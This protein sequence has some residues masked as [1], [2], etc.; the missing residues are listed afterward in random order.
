MMLHKTQPALRLAIRAVTVVF[1]LLFFEAG[2]A[3]SNNDKQQKVRGPTYHFLTKV[4][5]LMA[6]EKY[7]LA[8]NRID[9]FF[10]RV[11]HIALERALLNQTRVYILLAQE[12]YADA[13]IIIENILAENALPD[14]SNNDLRYNLA[15]LYMQNNAYQK[16][17]VQ[18]NI[19]LQTSDHKNVSNAHALTAYAH[20][21]LNSY[22]AA[23]RHLNKAIAQFESEPDQPHKK[24]SETWYQLLLASY[25]ELK[26][27]PDAG[28]LLFRMVAIFP[29][30]SL[31]WQQLSSVKLFLDEKQTALASLEVQSQISSPM[32]DDLLRLAR[33]NIYLNEPI[34]AAN[35]LLPALKN[36]KIKASSENYTLAADSLILA[37]EYKE[38]LEVLKA[39]SNLAPDNLR[40]KLRYAELLF[41]QEY[42]Q[43][44]VDVLHSLTKGSNKVIRARALLLH[45]ISAYYLGNIAISIASLE[46]ASQLKGSKEL[47]TI[48][49]YQVNRGVELAKLETD[50]NQTNQ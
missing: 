43:K 14:S 42:W 40:L 18:L 50:A 35:I 26:N 2:N 4:H 9:D 47:A 7:T 17:I 30:N 8:L 12:N 28:E 6:E 41:Q 34:N 15:Q 27:F 24:A 3:Q 21:S 25:Y 5:S 1:I 44:A 46:Q 32:G 33:L 11:E 39:A 45:G 23:I 36:K 48:W 49:L 13:I 10:H 31:Y 22:K 16:A 19:Y 37:R 20:Y 29:N 38:A